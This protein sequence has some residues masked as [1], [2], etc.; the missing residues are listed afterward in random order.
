M[1]TT[2]SSTP[3]EGSSSL[4]DKAYDALEDLIIRG[5]IPTGRIVSEGEFVERLQLGRTPIRE[6]VQRLAQ[7]GL[8]LI[9]PRKGL[10]VVEMS[11][12]RQLQTLEIRRPLERL[13]ASCAS[14]R[15]NPEQRA[16]MLDYARTTLEI[17]AL[18]DGRQFLAVIKRNHGLL[19][20]ASGNEL[21]RSVMALV[22]A[23]S[24]RFWF[25]HADEDALRIASQFHAALLKSVAAGDEAMALT[26][27]DRLIDYLEAFCRSTIEVYS[28]VAQRSKAAI[29]TTLGAV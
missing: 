5:E 24:R 25:S 11:V 16:V 2:L 10:L 26:D 21:I 17:G 9:L 12:T 7:E 29:H 23:R 14:Q 13:V 20:N 18:G 8:L 6:A 19:E 28:S 27:A 15:A 1:N 22:H 3:V 4:R